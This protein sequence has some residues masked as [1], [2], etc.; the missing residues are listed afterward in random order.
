M[1][2]NDLRHLRQTLFALQQNLG[3]TGLILRRLRRG[4]KHARHRLDV[5]AETVSVK[6]RREAEPTTQAG[7]PQ[8]SFEFGLAVQRARESA[9]LTRPKFAE[10]VNVSATTIANIEK[11]KRCRD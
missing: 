2:A 1:G 7:W 6:A 9:G 10:M 11:G 5:W 4:V 3:Q 8:D